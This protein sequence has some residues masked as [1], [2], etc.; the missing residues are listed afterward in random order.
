MKKYDKPVIDGGYPV[1]DGKLEF[2][3]P[4]INKREI[5]AVSKV[6]ESGWITRGPV[7]EEFE[8]RL[9]EYTGAPF[10]LVL[11]S[12]TAGLFLALK[13]Y[14]IGKGD[15]VITTPYTFAATANS[16]LHCG[17]TPV[18]ADI[19]PESFCISPEEIEKN[20]S[21]NTKAIIPVHFGG[22]PAEIEEILEI[23]Q[24]HGIKV[25]ED[26]AHA[27]GAK[28]KGKKI[29]NGDNIAVFSF[30]AVK[31]LTTAEGGAIMLKDRDM[32]KLIKL[33]SL[34]GQSKD[35]FKKYKGGNWEYDIEIPGY[36]FNMTDIQAAIGIEQLK[37]LEMNIK[38][39]KRI[40]EVYSK[41]FMNYDFV[42]TPV[43]KEY[44]ECSWHLYPILIDFSC[45]KINREQL[46]NALWEEGISLNVHYKPVHMMSYY[47]KVF[48][49]K[50]E[51]FP[52][53]YKV[54]TWEVSLP[55]YP[56]MTEKDIDD[57]TIAF[58]KIFNYYYGK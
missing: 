17:A 22:Q 6:L 39:R 54:Y 3:P 30:H 16:I 42:K 28:H 56:N 25:I 57:V 47:K 23:A 53:S 14:G 15:E 51:D 44:N 55:I 49:Y 33:Y 27:I 2:S 18:F 12:A 35:A 20:I 52:V 13:T 40:A 24:R 11:N 32:F 38:I 1:R 4:Y 41:F 5:E 46:I 31:N 43:C 34:H 45:L 8:K 37:K 21:S 26:S 50:A 19:D 7:C 48:G 29:G 36:K 9:L 58:R 10:C